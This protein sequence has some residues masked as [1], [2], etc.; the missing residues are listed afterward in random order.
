M[1]EIQAF[2]GLR[3]N[4]SLVRGSDVIS[5]PYDIVK[6]DDLHLLRNSGSE[7]DSDRRYNASILENPDPTPTATRAY[8]FRLDGTEHL[9][10]GATA[11]ILT[12][13]F[14]VLDVATDNDLDEEGVQQMNDFFE[15]FEE[16]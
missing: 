13:L 9:V 12:N 8:S 1:P 3:Y 4:P 7:T 6:L 16:N 15:L 14:H 5:P 2:Y 10:W 11:R